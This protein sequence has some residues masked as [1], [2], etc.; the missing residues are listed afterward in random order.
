MTQEIINTGTDENSGDGD[1]IRVAFTKVNSNFTELYA[2]EENT[3]QQTLSLDG[4]TLS[5]SNGNSVDLSK[6]VSFS[7][8]YND[9][10]DTPTLFN[11]DYNSLTNLPDLTQYVSRTEILNGTLSIDVNNTGDLYGSVYSDAGNLLVDGAN[12]TISYSVLVDTPTLF[13]GDY[14]SLTNLPDLTQYVSTTDL[15]NGTLTVDVT[16][17]GNL[18]GSVYSDAGDLLVDGAN[19]TIS[20][21]VLTDVPND[22][23]GFQTFKKQVAIGQTETVSSFPATEFRSA[24]FYVQTESNT[25]HRAGEIMLVHN[26]TSVDIIEYSVVEVGTPLGSFSSDIVNI[27]GIDTV[28]LL[29]TNNN[30]VVTDVVVNRTGFLSYQNA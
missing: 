2:R 5:I 7:G 24:K 14:N 21:N 15:N 23:F 12:G 29:F 1:T 30:D 19:G 26:G 22:F 13:D 11:G 4:N 25:H 9:L 17:N 8:S 16:N 28:R 3:D 18:Y 10:T 20:Y 27:D 6:Y